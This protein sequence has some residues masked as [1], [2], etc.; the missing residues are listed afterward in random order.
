MR[1]HE[2]DLADIQGNILR[3]YAF[4]HARFFQVSLKS[5]ESACAFMSKLLPLITTAEVWPDEK[6]EST[7]NIALGASALSL[8]ALPQGTLS[9][10]PDEFMEGMAKR[11]KSLGDTGESDPENWDNEWN[12]D[13][14]ALVT[15]YG[16]EPAHRESVSA[17]LNEIAQECGVQ[18]IAYQDANK[19]TID[20]AF[21]SKEHFGFTDGIA[22]PEFKHSHSRHTPGDGKLGKHG[23]WEFLETGDFL[24]GYANEA[25]EIEK[26]PDP[27]LFSKN[28]TFLVY[29][30][31]EQDVAGFRRY[32]KEQAANYP[33]GEEK[34]GAKLVGRW[35]DGTPVALSPD[36][37][38]S[39]ISGSAEK[40][41]DFRYGDDPEGLKCPLGAHVR[42][43]N[44]R[45]SLG[46][47][48]NL[49]ARRRIIRR[50]ISFG[51]YLRNDESNV[52]EERGLIFIVLNANISR[53][54]EFIQQQWMN[55]GNDF[56]MGDESDPIVGNHGSS[57]RYLIPGDTNKGEEPYVCTD[58][59]SFVKLRG[60]AYFFVPSIT[61]L[62]LLATNTVDVR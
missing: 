16:R 3:A 10:F 55:Y 14:D 23:G 21:S 61:A 52:N 36:K 37:P 57:Q 2:L 24:I 29:R 38:N 51:D 34:L 41:N 1:D 53:Q 35:A 32:V 25:Q 6:P 20:G 15:I 9:S 27:I 50:G 40:I 26:Y 8:F 60:G 22:Q 30:K 58:M 5:A 43:A 47:K 49:T 7:L 48:D 18:I 56:R 17:Q 45:D 62:R 54:F 31:L 28:G 19:L 33:G 42:R 12:Q 44:P 59:N 13:V 39:G 11:A 46:F 4:P